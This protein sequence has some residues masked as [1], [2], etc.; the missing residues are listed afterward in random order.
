[1]V[2]QQTFQAIYQLH[3]AL[4][5]G[6]RNVTFCCSKQ[7]NHTF[8]LSNLTQPRTLSTV[9]A[10]SG[11]TAKLIQC[12]CRLCLCDSTTEM[13]VMNSL[14]AFYLVQHRLLFSFS[15]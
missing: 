7:L 9:E 10:M 5:S 1:M 12:T 3:K 11:P 15:P 4:H 8:L 2:L 6:R 13:H 14:N